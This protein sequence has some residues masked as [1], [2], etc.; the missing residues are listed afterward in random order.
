MHFVGNNAWFAALLTFHVVSAIAGIGPAFA[1]GVLGPMAGKAEPP[2]NLAVLEAIHGIERFHLRPSTLLTQWGSGVLLIFN[3]GLNHGFFS[4]QRA[5]LLIAI[6]IY[7]V[8]VLLGELY[9]APGIQKQLAFAR[10][11]DRLPP[12][13]GPDK[14]MNALFP[15]LTV[16]IIVLMV[17]KPGS[18]CL[19]FTC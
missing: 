3:R 9:A 12:P 4:S 11:G 5:W 6:G 7:I 17:W 18:G 15:L 8:L 10:A 19:N 1:F 2:K 13:S 14:L 16:A